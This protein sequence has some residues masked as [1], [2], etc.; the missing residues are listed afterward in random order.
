MVWKCNKAQSGNQFFDNITVLHYLAFLHV[1]RNN[2]N[3]DPIT[4]K[5]IIEAADV[6]VPHIKNVF[7]SS[8]LGP[9]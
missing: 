6:L 5:A 3:D 9:F 2:L 8:P 4:L 7:L 1:R